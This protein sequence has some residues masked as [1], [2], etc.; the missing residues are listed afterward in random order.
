MAGEFTGEAEEVT[1]AFN[2]RYLQD[3]VSAISGERVRIQVI[4][5][6]KPSVISGTEDP[7]FLYLLMPVRI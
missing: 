6:L 2:P 4:D 3:G 5:G 7:S 1:I